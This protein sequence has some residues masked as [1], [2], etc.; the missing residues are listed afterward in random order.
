MI[1]E[2][3]AAWP[4]IWTEHA[5]ERAA[6]RLGGADQLTVPEPLLRAIAERKS[7]AEQFRATVF[8][9]VWICHRADNG[10][11]IRTVFPCG[12]EEFQEWE[13]RFKRCGRCGKRKSTLEFNESRITKDGLH[14]CCQSCQHKQERR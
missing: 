13:E 5:R 12:R 9:V 10:I 14:Y 8:G 3:Q 4:V 11:V 7:L 6:E 1:H 2:Q